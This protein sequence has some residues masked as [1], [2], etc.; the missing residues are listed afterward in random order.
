MNAP[1]EFIFSKDPTTRQGKKLLNDNLYNLLNFS[2]KERK[3]IERLSLLF[4]KKL[5]QAIQHST[6]SHLIKQE[7]ELNTKLRS[8]IIERAK[9][10]NSKVNTTLS[11]LYNR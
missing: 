11:K 3:R 5:N 9:D 6:T 8:Q 2:Q 4:S 1:K 10:I 7:T